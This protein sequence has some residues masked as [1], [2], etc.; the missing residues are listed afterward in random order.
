MTIQIERTIREAYVQASS[1]L[2]Q[3]GVPDHAFTAELLLRHLLKWTRSEW[4]M[5]W[6]EPFPVESAAQWDALLAR[7]A[8][9]EP[10]QYIIEEQEFYGLPFTVTSAV[11]IPRPETELLVEEAIRLGRKLWDEQEKLPT[12][13]DIG[14]GTGAIAVSLAAQCPGWSLIAVDISEQAL[15]IAKRNAEING[16]SESIQFR[17]GDLL[18]PLISDGIAVDMLLSNPPYIPAE[19]WQGLQREVRDYEP[20]TALVGGADGLDFY[21]AIIEQLAELPQYPAIVGFEVGMGQAGDV[22]QLLQSRK[23]WEEIRIVRDLA[24]IERHVIAVAQG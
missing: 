6:D 7:R 12:V 3:A 24:G 16:V 13:A 17:A 1:F 15:Q 4:F 8:A 9:G 19:E 20:I 10:V 22:A 2:A 5:R 21:R 14:T 11:L 23:Q 18:K